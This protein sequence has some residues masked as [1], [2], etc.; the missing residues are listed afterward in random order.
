MKVLHIETVKELMDFTEQEME[1]VIE[2]GP[3][4]IGDG[5]RPSFSVEP[6]SPDDGDNICARAITWAEKKHYGGDQRKM[7]LF[8]TTV[9]E[10]CVRLP[11]GGFPHGMDRLE[12]VARLTMC[13]T[14]GLFPLPVH[15]PEA[16]MKFT[17]A[18]IKLLD[19]LIWGSPDDEIIY[20]LKVK[21]F[22][23]ELCDDDAKKKRVEDELNRLRTIEVE[24]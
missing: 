20:S 6:G 5:W 16:Y 17:K 2:E 9:A 18:A 14:T 4:P 19:E 13:A 10:W 11:V 1:E 23:D 7:A 3:W 8:A 21:K 24:K 12:E 15:D 22:V